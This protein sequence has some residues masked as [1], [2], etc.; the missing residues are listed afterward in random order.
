MRLIEEVKINNVIKEIYY[1]NFE[2]VQD[3]I[4]LIEILASAKSWWQ[5][6]ISLRSFFNDDDIVLNLDGNEIFA[7][8]SKDMD[9][10]AVWN[11]N[12]LKG[13][14]KTVLLAVRLKKG[15]HT[16]SFKPDKRPSLENIRMMELEPK[17]NNKII[18]VP[19]VNNPPENGD[20]RPWISYFFLNLAV[21]E[22][23]ILAGADKEGRDDQDI[24]LIVDGEVEMSDEK[25]SH[26][27][28]LWCGKV[29]K[30][31]EKE[32]KKEVNMQEGK[33]FVELWADK[34]PYL[35]KMEVIVAVLNNGIDESSGKIIQP[36]L[37]G[38]SECK[39]DY[40]RYDNIISDAVSYWNNEFLKD[41]DP[42]DEILDPNLVKAI[43]YQESRIG[44]DKTA[45]V[46]VM[47]VGNKGDPSILTL[48][49]ELPEYWIHNGKTILLKYNAEVKSV[50]ESVNWGVRWLY[51]KAQGSTK[52][53]KR[54]WIPWREAVI[55]YGPPKDEYVSSVWGIY[56]QGIKNDK[57]IGIIRLW[58][59]VLIIMTLFLN[60]GTV[61]SLENQIRDQIIIDGQS[62][63]LEGIELAHNQDKKYFLAQIEWEKDWWEELKIGR[64]EDKSIQWFRVD[65]PPS[66]QAIL[67]ARFIDLNDFSNP[68]VEVYGLT[69]VG[70]GF[71]YIYEIYNGELR[72]L[73]KTP[74]VD[75]N[76]DIR[77]APGNY[78]R[79]G[80]GNCGEIFSGGRLMGSYR[81]VNR[82]GMPD[83]L[84]DGTVEVVCEKMD[85][86]Y[87][88]FDKVKTDERE[89]EKVF[90]WDQN[91]QMW[92]LSA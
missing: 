15:N 71:L 40:N 18:Y 37:C 75:Y 79:Y 85:K 24:K 83:V 47:Q 14:S 51:H 90:L 11:G 50:E 6:F 91:K 55:K 17:D 72:L 5:N 4:F 48:K 84:L 41:T 82:D 2:L 81:D 8:I 69:H 88:Y 57:K 10:K 9:V 32:F 70:H 54:Y 35:K 30:G 49:G 42:P 39:E 23:T 20:R 61:Y 19:T 31:K 13:L 45:G 62:E 29:L 76:P 34:S 59:I 86:D 92:I 33:H 25:K 28:W 78:E 1:Y 26:K 36:Y 74:A 21:A 52:D 53:K 64:V 77:W 58:S 73:L 44:F 66:E 60:G 12:E 46:N 67:S 43:I 87:R 7:S 63:Q 56:K 22:L 89:V 38:G 65:E 3:G 68:L 16:L 27:D 80:Y